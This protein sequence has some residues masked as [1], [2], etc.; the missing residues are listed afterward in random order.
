ML[1][2][3]HPKVA[4]ADS[5]AISNMHQLCLL[6]RAKLRTAVVN[7][8]GTFCERAEAIPACKQ[9]ASVWAIATEQVLMHNESFGFR[10]KFK[11]Y[12]LFY[13]INSHAKSTTCRSPPMVAVAR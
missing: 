11:M 9:D 6:C 12:L 8:A 1:K 3:F 4:V 2:F 10:V 5:L 7:Q 13:F